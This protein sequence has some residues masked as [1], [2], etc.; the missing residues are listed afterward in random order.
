MDEVVKGISPGI[1]KQ[2]LV[3]D[4][5]VAFLAAGPL[6]QN[7]QAVLPSCQTLVI[8]VSNNPLGRVDVDGVL[9]PLFTVGAVLKADDEFAVLFGHGIIAVQ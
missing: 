2:V 1:V 8:Q 9:L 7:S 5:L 6:P 3:K 4:G